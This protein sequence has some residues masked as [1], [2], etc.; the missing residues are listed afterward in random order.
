MYDSTSAFRFNYLKLTN[1]RVSVPCMTGSHSGVL[2]DDREGLLQ[3]G[4]LGS[5]SEFL[6]QE[7]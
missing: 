6:T 1:S 3:P 7:V 5:T 2:Q 4:L